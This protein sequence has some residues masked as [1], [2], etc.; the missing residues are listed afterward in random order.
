MIKFLNKVF[1]SIMELTIY[2]EKVMNFTAAMKVLING[3]SVRLGPATYGLSA[4]GFSLINL[5]SGETVALSVALL[6]ATTY[7]NAGPIIP[8]LGADAVYAVFNEEKARWVS[9][10]EAAKHKA[11]GKR[12]AVFVLDELI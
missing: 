12:V 4:D 6:D 2:E 11:A 3:G 9:T 5:A 8:T 7:V 1:A 10:T